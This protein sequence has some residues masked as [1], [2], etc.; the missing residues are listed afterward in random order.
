MFPS[1]CTRIVNF[2]SDH[3]RNEG[4]FCAARIAKIVQLASGVRLMPAQVSPRLGRVIQWNQQMN[5]QPRCL[6]PGSDGAKPGRSP[7]DQP[8]I[9]RM[10]RTV[11]STGDNGV[12]R[13]CPPAFARG[14]LLLRIAHKTDVEK[15]GRSEI[16]QHTPPCRASAV[17][18]A[19]WPDRPLSRGDF[20]TGWFGSPLERGGAIVP[21]CVR[22]ICE[23]K[24]WS[25]AWIRLIRAIHAR[26]N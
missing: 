24:Y 2:S 18:Q 21:G 9:A 8:R 22:L 6:R 15:G 1:G 11:T 5:I 7:E 23:F 10:T 12:N 25:G 20:R 26:Q 19:L 3:L 16:P 14:L 13:I 17:D 4:D